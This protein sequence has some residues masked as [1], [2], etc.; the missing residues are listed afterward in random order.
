MELIY[1]GKNGRQEPHADDATT[2][3][4]GEQQEHKQLLPIEH[5]EAHMVQSTYQQDNKYVFKFTNVKTQISKVVTF[6]QCSA[7]HKGQSKCICQHLNLNTRLLTLLS[8][9]DA[10]NSANSTINTLTLKI[11]HDRSEELFELL[12]NDFLTTYKMKEYV[13]LAEN[14]AA[15]ANFAKH[16]NTL[17][18]NKQFDYV[19]FYFDQDPPRTTFSPTKRGRLTAQGIVTDYEFTEKP[20]NQGDPDFDVNV[21]I[22]DDE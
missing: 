16:Y 10:N 19:S 9:T 21:M 15:T 8:L 3:R 11:F 2:R 7:C 17:L 4:H 14:P 22:T 6:V 12:D 5:K 18:S 20:D 1:L 13:T